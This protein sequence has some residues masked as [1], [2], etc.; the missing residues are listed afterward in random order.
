MM[1]SPRLLADRKRKLVRTSQPPGV[2]SLNISGKELTFKDEVLNR[3]VPTPVHF[4]EH[5]TGII[6]QKIGLGVWSLLCM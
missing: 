6:T 1:L 2:K 3:D 4:Q 5:V